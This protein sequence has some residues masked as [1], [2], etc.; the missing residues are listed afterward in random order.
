MSNRLMHAARNQAG[1]FILA[2]MFLLSAFGTLSA[3]EREDARPVRRILT[4]SSYRITDEWA[5]PLYHSIVENSRE[6][7]ER[8]LYD[9]TV[10]LYGRQNRDRAVFEAE[11]PKYRRE[12]AKGK[13]AL[14]L[15]LGD[16]AAARLL[17]HYGEIPRGMPI[18][19]SGCENCPA[20]LRKIYP[21][22]TGVTMPVETDET[23]WAILGLCP[24]TREIIILGDFTDCSRSLAE[25]IRGRH[26]LPSGVT[27]TL[28]NVRGNDIDTLFVSLKDTPKTTQLLLLPWRSGCGNE[29]HSIPA[30]GLE[31]RKSLGKPFFVCADSLFGYGALG[32]YLTETSVLGQQT[33]TVIHDVLKNGAEKTPMIPGRLRHVY[34]YSL[35]EENGLPTSSLPKGSVL[36]NRPASFLQDHP[37]LAGSAAAGGLFVIVCAVI[38]AL[39]ARWTMRRFLRMCEALP[40][41]IGALDRNEN[42]LFT[43]IPRTGKWAA[44]KTLRDIPDIDYSKVSAALHDVFDSKSPVSLMYEHSSVRRH[45]RFA[46][47]PK[48]IFGKDAVIWLSHD[49]REVQDTLREAERLAAERKSQIRLWDL[50][51]NSLP[52]HIFIKE[53]N[54][55]YR[56]C[57]RAMRKF[58]HIGENEPADRRDSD[59]FPEESCAVL[60]KIDSAILAADGQA[61]ERVVRLKNPQGE[62]VC[63]RFTGCACRDADGKEL[64]LGA[65]LDITEYEKTRIEL[66]DTL[67]KYNFLLD[68]LPAYIFVKDIDNGFRYVS[69]NRAGQQV[70]GAAQESEII[71]KNDSQLFGPELGARLQ[72]EA[73]NTAG[74]S[75]PRESDVEFSDKDGKRRIGHFYSRRLDTAGGRHLI[76]SFGVDTTEQE[77][78]KAEL[79]DT[80]AM[81]RLMLD[82]TPAYFVVKDPSR[83]FTIT[84][85]NRLFREKIAR[86]DDISGLT[87]YDFLTVKQEADRILAF[88]REA[89]RL[90]CETTHPLDITDPDGKRRR[91]IAH[92]I[93]LRLSHSR[94][95]LFLVG[96]D[97]T[98]TE[99]ARSR[100]EN[101]EEG[102]RLTLNAIGDGVL[103][104]DL[105]GRIVLL[106]PVAERLLGC[107]LQEAQGRPHEQFFN[108]VSAGDEQPLQ[109]PVSRSLRTGSTVE[110]ANHTVLLSRD[111]K[112]YQISDSAAPIRSRLGEII[113]GILI[114]RDITEEYESRD[115][116][117]SA[118]ANLENSARFTRSA[119]FLLDRT[120]MKI[121]GSKFLSELLPIRDGVLEPEESWVFADDLPGLRRQIAG[122]YTYSQVEA[123]IQFRC[124]KDGTL[125]FCRLLCWLEKTGSHKLLNGVIQDVT[126]ITRSAVRLKETQELWSRVIDLS[127]VLFFA[128]DADNGMRYLLC[129]QAL[130]SV[131]GKT[132]AEII[133]KTDA[134]LGVP[135]DLVKR[136]YQ[137]DISVMAKG[138][139]LEVNSTYVDY[140]GATRHL[141]TMKQPFSGTNGRKLLLGVASDFTELHNLLECE[142]ISNSLLSRTVNEP[143][144]DKVLGCIADLLREQMNCT[145]VIITKCN[146]EG[147]PRLYREWVT[148]GSR[149]LET[150]EL[151]KHYKLWDANIGLMKKGVILRIP[152]MESHEITRSLVKGRN[153]IS[154]SL[155]VA[156]VFVEE[157]LWGTML[158][159]M[160]KHREEFSVVAD[161]LIGTCTSVIALAAI[162]ERQNRAIKTADRERRMVMDNIGIP[163]WLHDS[164]GKL[165]LVNSGVEK[166]E[167]VPADKLTTAG[168][169]SF[170]DSALPLEKEQPVDEAIRT[171]KPA[172]AEVSF[173]G[174]DY[175]VTA[176]PVFD[177]EKLSFVVKSAVD[178]TELNESICDQQLLSA[179]Q[180]VL[181]EESNL[182]KSVSSVLK[183]LC[184]HIH[185]ARCYIARYNLEKR[186]LSWFAESAEGG[187]VHPAGVR[188]RPIS[189]KPYWPAIFRTTPWISV[190]D[191]R[192]ASP[193]V[194]GPSWD[195][196]I[197]EDNLRSH[198]AY[199]I[200]LNGELFGFLGIG[201]DDAPRVMEDSERNMVGTIAY[202]VSLMLERDRA[203][204]QMLAA[205]HHAQ[206]ADRAKSYFIASV[207]HEIRTPLNA[208]IGF[209]ELLLKTKVSGEEAKEYL[210]NIAFSGNALLQ[211]INDVLDL[212][213]L[214]AGQM[215]ILPEPCG[216]GELARSVLKVFEPQASEK[217]I[218][219]RAEIPELPVMELDK[220]RIRQILFNLIGNAVKF[221]PSGTV[222][223]RAGF[224][225]GADGTGA[226]EFSVSD[227]GIGISEA[228]KSRLMEP[229]VQLSRMRGTNS[230]SNGTGLGLSICRRL[231]EKMGG[232]IRIESTPG[233]GST[234][235]VTLSAAYRSGESLPAEVETP[236][237]ALKSVEP[238]G[239]ISLLLVDD[240]P[241]NLKV[242]EAI[243]RKCG[244]EDF[245][246]ASSGKEALEKLGAKPCSIVLTDLWMP[247]MNGVE[248]A[249]RI[250][251]EHRFDSVRLVAV[252]ADM[253]AAGNFDMSVFSSILLKP[254]TLEKIRRVCTSLSAPE[255]KEIT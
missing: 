224:Q 72:E 124:R 135:E 54:G 242:M 64:L 65:A 247:E 217:K 71:G 92:W 166:L 95:I 74:S 254:V 12:L 245:A 177:S 19:L 7:P 228:D 146:E 59:F 101:Q 195:K 67:V 70:L 251:K 120:T 29:Y 94:E 237:P 143:D 204:T 206:E 90:G 89:V 37:V 219:L 205:L 213:R 198:Y 163:L 48:D 181:L 249:R 239:K 33:A 234:F 167:G 63:F 83:N 220:L 255:G 34:D 16:Q 126:D 114:F 194:M 250:R 210:G 10:E 183:L 130:A 18:V 13:Y 160:E 221:T 151:E 203:R 103:T 138:T 190:P 141:R 52:H 145:H 175:V 197:R 182:E 162:R 104:T 235:F 81:L 55:G 192:N 131:I 140:T 133:G 173:G 137:E 123:E 188:D 144:F 44:V 56:F 45:L 98:E 97:M 38:M 200:M 75:I 108:I 150:L 121:S 58:H 223:L 159:S 112:R 201:Y 129:N 212:S 49:N 106:N 79:L 139:R 109:S 187:R 170:F 179:C 102:F 9:S 68:D 113:G 216:F 243:C 32:G 8:L 218:A 168:N 50:L 84:M 241:L 47:L 214:E 78:N 62:P 176:R 96:N 115:R 110:L 85:S 17:E 77:K 27:L 42:V 253:E 21:N 169:R 40:G 4:I 209:A 23:I 1:I 28:K 157:K 136:F 73:R 5:G 155:I 248:L 66:A 142:Q 186:T 193:D 24:N 240:V 100:A 211:L 86:K 226:L 185:A 57:S 174:R 222:T 207:S 152:D 93:P 199:R 87:D 99:E 69:C 125:R 46:P 191:V 22:V 6:L 51:I 118:L 158:V 196:M 35:L 180:S 153:F 132:A 225:P 107:T 117:R 246:S 26:I 30:F 127:P 149:P 229:F 161:R 119:S 148:S 116:L 41:R 31:L 252:T 60:A 236:S 202:F 172:R 36:L 80:V 105:N 154:Q 227:T 189:S 3:A 244:Y 147:M 82:N 111:G 122:L 230:A 215:E 156:P 43:N 171:G 231:I 208:V 2:A 25:Q 233:K 39:S 15:A 53:R 128:K 164:S 20:D 232:T 14:I 76:F 184:G 88:D 165:L 91:L 178:I 238:Q 134:E 11:W 61:V